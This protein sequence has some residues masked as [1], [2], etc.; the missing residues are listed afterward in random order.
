[1][2]WGSS[3]K[4]GSKTTNKIY[5]DGN[6]YSIAVWENPYILMSASEVWIF[7][8]SY[9]AIATIVLLAIGTIVP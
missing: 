9:V 7:S 2:K 6:Y 4:K 8:H 5:S 1:M 3:N